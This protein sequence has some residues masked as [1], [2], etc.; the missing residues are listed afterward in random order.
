VAVLIYCKN[1]FLDLYLQ[2]RAVERNKQG[3][4]LM[5][6]IEKPNVVHAKVT[7]TY[8]DFP[9]ALLDIHLSDKKTYAAL[10]PLSV[11]ESDMTNDWIKKGDA[12]TLWVAQNHKWKYLAYKNTIITNKHN[13]SSDLTPVTQKH[14]D[15]YKANLESKLELSKRLDKIQQSVVIVQAVDTTGF[16]SVENAKKILINHLRC[17]SELINE[18]LRQKKK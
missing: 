16:D 10:P 12:L 5:K 4:S 1:S 2:S 8:H 18:E 11:Y 9:N 13:K 3:R 17:Q 6:K 14:F 7:S 15:D